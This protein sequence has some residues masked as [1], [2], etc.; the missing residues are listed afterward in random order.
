[1]LDWLEAA[2]ALR[3]VVYLVAHN[4]AEL[5]LVTN[6]VPAALAWRLM[7]AAPL[8]PM[9]FLLLTSRV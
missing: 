9:L 1:M 5:P 3:W 8:Q 4:T 2:L 6:E 7:F